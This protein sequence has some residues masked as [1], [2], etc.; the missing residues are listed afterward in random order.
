MNSPHDPEKLIQFHDKVIKAAQEL[1]ELLSFAPRWTQLCLARDKDG[2]ITEIEAT[3]QE[4]PVCFCLVGGIHKV[5][6]DEGRE[7]YLSL[8][9]AVE[10]TIM[11]RP[12]FPEWAKKRLDGSC[13]ANFNDSYGRKHE[14]IVQVLEAVVKDVVKAKE[15]RCGVNGA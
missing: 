7:V 9:C 6:K 14:E 2:T 10:R 4:A 3:G 8:I 12:N 15:E 1:K 5:S 13:I 11:A